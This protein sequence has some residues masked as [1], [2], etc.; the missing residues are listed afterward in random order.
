MDAELFVLIG[1]GHRGQDGGGRGAVQGVGRQTRNFKREKETNRDR[2]QDR[3]I[4]QL[5]KKTEKSANR[6]Q[7]H[8]H[9]KIHRIECNL[10]HLLF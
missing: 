7:N 3:T 8:R 4:I 5:N 2:D 10:L 1:Q 9:K 6:T